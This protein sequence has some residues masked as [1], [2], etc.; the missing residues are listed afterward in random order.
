[1]LS[2]TGDFKAKFIKFVK[3]RTETSPESILD[4]LKSDK[5]AREYRYIHWSKLQ[6]LIIDWADQQCS[7]AIRSGSPDVFAD[8]EQLYREFAQYWNKHQLDFF[9]VYPRARE[10]NRRQLDYHLPQC[11]FELLLDD[12]TGSD[13]RTAT[14]MVRP[15]DRQRIRSNA[16]ELSYYLL[17]LRQRMNDRV[18]II[19]QPRLSHMLKVHSKARNR[20]KYDIQFNDDIRN[21]L[22][23][24]QYRDL[25]SGKWEIIQ[26]SQGRDWLLEVWGDFLTR[27]G[28]KEI[29][30]FQLKCFRSLLDSALLADGC[31][32][33]IMIT[34]G[35]GFGKTEA[36]LFPILFYA[37][38]NLLRQR[39]RLFG[40]D[41][42]LVYPRIDLCNNQLE[43]Y[44]WYA[45]CLKESVIASPRTEAI[46]D[47]T[48][49]EMFR[50][51]L[52]HGGAK[53]V[54]GSGGEP[55][56]VECPMCKEEDQE[57]FINIRKQ[58]GRGYQ[59]TPFCS[60]DENHK[61][62]QYLIPQLN[63]WNRGRFTV[64]ISTVDTL[65]RRLMDLHGRSTLW[66]KS[67][68]LPRFIVLDEIHIY[69]GQ[70]GSHVANLVRRLKVYLKDIRQDDNCRPNPLP[71]IFVGSSAT[72][73]NPQ[74]V[75]S[76]IFGISEIKMNNRVLKPEEV[77]SE[78]LG[79]EYTYLLKTP[80]LREIQ[81]DNKGSNRYRVVSEQASLLQALMVF[82]HAMRKTLPQQ[83]SPGKYR[84]LTFV[85]SIDSVWRIA[86]NLDDAESHRNKQLYKFRIPRGR[87][88]NNNNTI[89]N[90]NINCPKFA[91]KE[92]CETPPHQFFEGCEIYQQGECWW[93][94]GT[95]P[96]EF[97]RPMQVV[98]KIS[99][100]TKSPQNF[101]R[102]QQLDQ[103]DCMIATSTLEVGFDHSELIATAQFKAPTNPASFQQRKGRGGR[104]V[105]DI[106]LTLMVLGN[107]PGD[108][109]AFKHEQRYFEPTPED[110]KIQFD[111]KN[112]FIRNQ[113]V[114]SAIYDFMS[115]RGITQ[116]W[117]DIYDKCNIRLALDNLERYREDLNNWIID[118]YGSDGMSREE[119][120]KLVSQCISQMEQSVVS[121][122]LDF[123]GICNS[124]DLFQ[125]E[126]IPQEW[127]IRLQDRIDQGNFVLIDRRT[128]V[129]I[130]AAERWTK[131]YLHP[132]YY[133]NRLPI[134]N[135]GNSRDPSWVIPES[136]IP[137]PIGGTITVEE[138]GANII[139]ETEP[140]LQTLASFLPGGYKHR[141][142]FKL[143]YG[144]WLHVPDQDNCAD[145][146][147]L[148]RDAEDLG[149][150]QDSLVGRPTP[151]VLSNF[152]P[153]STQLVNPRTI[154]VQEGQENFY[155]TRDRTRVKNVNDV[156]GGVLLSREPSSIAQ[157]HDLIVEQSENLVPISLNGNSFG[158]KR[159]QFGENDLLRLFYSNLVNCYPSDVGNAPQPSLSIN[160]KFYDREKRKH[161]IPTVKLHTQGIS[162]EGSLSQDDI[163]QKVDQCK[164]VGT[165]EEHYWRL[166]YRLLWR[167]A[168]LN[169]N[170]SD[171]NIDFSYDCIK[172][173]R[174]LR[175]L[176]FQT[177]LVQKL[178]LEFISD[179][180]IESIFKKSLK[181]CD[182]LH[183]DLF[184]CEN[185]I[186]SIPTCWSELRDKIL[187][188]TRAEL[189]MEIAE[190]FA[191]TMAMAICRDIAEKTNTNLD[192]IETSVEVYQLDNEDHYT[193]RACVYDNIEGGN[194]TTSSYVNHIKKSISL[195]AICAKQKRCDTNRDEMA[196][197]KLLRNQSLNADMLYSMVNTS[198]GLEKLHLSEQAKFKVN[199]LISSPSITAF[200]Q[201]VAENY[202]ELKDL[203]QREPGE[204]ELACY[205]T[206]R[207]IA[208]PRGN[209]LY[210]QF[211]TQS[212]GISE[213]IPRI[214]EIMPL[215]HGSCPD[216]LG[217]SRLSFEKGERLIADRHYLE[218]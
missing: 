115:W 129:V 25:A 201:G 40:P 175:F 63:K 4:I 149:T 74:E 206:E 5:T 6:L 191:Q 156:Q 197:L 16:Y 88:D 217:D 181:I 89:I 166:V 165:Y 199:R 143:W 78:P 9:A 215:C 118:L 194:G 135:N 101:P 22:I 195:E 138:T 21:Y 176:D 27:I 187:I 144:E 58:P 85:D 169:H 139:T 117:S 132:P 24:I 75:G 140:K 167:E 148:A 163:Q 112:K 122:N 151:P 44:L 209:Q 53:P 213:L 128:L 38:I 113:H 67:E 102:D 177:R 164:T 35:T 121:L 29:A 86:R 125:R 77:E 146:S 43:R 26:Q 79:R 123:P 80:P 157:T 15:Y 1:M 69:E 154:Q 136:F 106:P 147:N 196:I 111:A 158:V 62:G 103:W 141:W 152:I 119:G 31:P 57:G 56:S 3:R 60:R 90:G 95:S 47:Y 145:I 66:K 23:D 71:P 50:A 70:Y 94:M 49:T 172:I 159:I 105:E 178:S 42:I 14:K 190:S 34:A 137:L 83:E 28:I 180:E 110:L 150:L 76:N 54:N 202:E 12:L 184:D 84:L 207:P 211:I 65:H 210:E 10:W 130:Q 205:L 92:I 185:I 133:Y 32:E 13:D 68:F 182:K 46:L 198:E 203:L 116:T 168:F 81:D 189:Q 96:D 17:N 170:L 162:L 45:H 73:G 126:V 171:F 212:G 192:L 19:E 59:L 142:G 127:R 11:L 214:A 7:G 61:V 218:A 204:E 183:F 200:Y 39:S 161:S 108:L 114:L 98:S 51:N 97:L 160:L 72:I 82:W 2:V 87:W 124:V 188:R 48:P 155:L 100:F 109:F 91:C 208:D 153:Q 33:P 99:G 120:I 20:P 193:F 18:A 41:A 134:D 36:F 174:I 179:T 30:P 93:S 8:I 52:G 186:S 107:S 173:L 55:F 104:G 216:C 37:T 64:A 131:S